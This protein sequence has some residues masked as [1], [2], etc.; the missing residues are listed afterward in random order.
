M[1][2]QIVTK[3]A[4]GAVGPYSQAIVVGN[5]LYVSGQIPLNPATGELVTEIG[6]AAQQVLENL[7]AILAAADYSMDDVVKTVVYLADIDN[8]VKVNEIYAK[9]FR[10]P[11]PARSCVAVK[12]LPKGALL[13]IECIAVK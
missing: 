11:Y 12:D 4:P 13:E 9:Y 1:K 7:Q 6:A 5:T 10:E 8:F 2:K 3:N